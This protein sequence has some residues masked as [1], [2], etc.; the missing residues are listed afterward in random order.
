MIGMLG[1]FFR[2]LGGVGIAVGGVGAGVSAL[3]HGVSLSP[4]A[5]Y[6]AKRKLPEG[7]EPSEAQIDAEKDKAD[8]MISGIAAIPIAGFGAWRM[9]GAGDYES[10]IL[11]LI[12]IMMGGAL[13][14]ETGSAVEV[15]GSLLKL[16]EI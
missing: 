6:L 11:D 2:E 15:L 4:L 9:R 12:G 16:G 10:D 13:F 5:K 1:S 7:I 3:A 14:Y 8:L